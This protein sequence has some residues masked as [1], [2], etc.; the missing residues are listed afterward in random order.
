MT[1]FFF[2]KPASTVYR[3]RFSSIN[4]RPR[5]DR[6]L[7][8]STVVN[9]NAEISQKQHTHTATPQS[10]EKS[11]LLNNRL[12]VRALKHHLSGLNV[13]SSQRNDAESITSDFFKDDSDVAP[14][15]MSPNKKGA[16]AA[17][18]NKSRNQKG[19]TTAL[20]RLKTIS[21]LEN[22]EIVFHDLEGNDE[23]H[24]CLLEAKIKSNFVC[25][26]IGENQPQARENAAENLL[27]IIDFF[28]R[29]TNR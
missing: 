24:L 9:K 22:F 29:K 1:E 23:V 21:T 25:H 14:Y 6:P 3:G 28:K 18:L 12:G 8:Y 2:Q 5:D 4:A 10:T 7:I 27:L 16:I 20:E 11:T 13:A 26:G 19:F 17:S 15:R